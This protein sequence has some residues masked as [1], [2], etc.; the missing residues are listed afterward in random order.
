MLNIMTCLT[1]TIIIWLRLIRSQ[2]FADIH[3]LYWGLHY[4]QALRWSK[5]KICPEKRLQVR[6][7]SAVLRRHGGSYRTVED[8]LHVVQGAA[9]QQV[10][11]RTGRYARERRNTGISNCSPVV[12]FMIGACIATYAVWWTVDIVINRFLGLA[13]TDRNGNRFVNYSVF[14]SID[15]SLSSYWMF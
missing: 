9:D 3:S 13:D 10:P 8:P 4:R 7:R 6:V 12:M 14:V 5:Q 11:S 2:G 1:V 15:H